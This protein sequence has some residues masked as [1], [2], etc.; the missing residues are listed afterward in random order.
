VKPATD[1]RAER[2]ADETRR[3]RTGFLRLKSALFDPVTSLYSYN[4][5]LDQLEMQCAG[6]RLGVIVVEFP[7]FGALEQTY[8]WEVGDRFLTGV[9]AQLKSLKGRIYPESTLVSLEGV[10]GN[11]FTLFLK[12]GPGGRKVG[13]ADLADACAALAV[14]LEIRLAE[15]AWAPT[16]PAIDC[17]IGY[18][19]VCPNPAARFERMVH[20]GVREARGMTL[21]DADR[22][23]GQR[24]AEL[25]T[26]MDE[27][28]LTTHY[29]PIVDM[30]LDAIMGYEALTRGP[31]NT[32]FAVPKALF[33]VS[34]ASHLSGELD[35]L[36]GQRAL[37]GARGFDPDKKLFLNS[38][39][40]TLG[41]PGLIERNLAAVLEEVA[42][43]P[44]NLVL[45][46]TERTAIEDFESFGR[47]LERLRR[48]GFLVAIDDV[49]T[50]YSSLQTISEIPA[51]FLK[52]DISLIKNLHQSLIKQDLVH[53]LLQVA[54]RTRTRVIA[55]GIETAEE[56]QALRACGVRYGQG[57]Y[58]ARP[59]P[60][61]PVLARGGKGSA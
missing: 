53:S 6:L 33:T 34:D 28:L 50:G 12:E 29:Q 4:L 18:S 1:P 5:H 32:A 45:E 19:L 58:F 54:S 30:D 20:Q 2:Q 61:F 15:A 25:R 46:I 11:A 60:A 27:G 38:L 26:I 41:T 56:Y 43:R 3:L 8:G 37:R 21:R 49:G 22:V 17:S 16:P 40:E 14:H 42:L 48:I 59:A 57:F 35:A 23:Q 47:E 31:E 7:A 52:I 55:E 10:Y 44:H 36:C 13:V 9:A 51:D 24:A 39:P